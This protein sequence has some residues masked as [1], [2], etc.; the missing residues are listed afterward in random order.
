MK[1]HLIVCGGTFDQWHAG[2]TSFIRSILALSDQVLLG[3]TSDKYVA[4]NKASSHPIQAFIERKKNVEA[5]LQ[6]ENAL[7]RVTIA[8]I[9]TVFYPEVWEIMPI[10]AIAVTKETETGAQTINND[11]EQRGLLPLPIVFIP[12]VLDDQGEK[13]ASTHIREGKVN[14]QGISYIQSS[15]FRSDLFLPEI[16]K[17]W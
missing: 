14:N 3:I 10:E 12:I 17:Q 4:D 8:P 11:R 6:N 15:W 5:F 7:N 13:L 16:E 2:H 1:Y 9:D